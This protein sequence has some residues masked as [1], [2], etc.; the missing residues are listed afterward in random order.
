MLSYFE[1]LF[2]WSISYWMNCSSFHLGLVFQGID[3]FHLSCQI[4]VCR[5]FCCIPLFF[6]D[7]CRAHNNILCFIQIMII[8]VFSLF[9]F[10]SFA[11]GLSFL[12]I[13]SK[14]Q[15]FV[16]WFFYFFCFDFIYFFSW[17]YYF[18]SS[19]YFVLF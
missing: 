3:L 6:F 8:S 11:R 10:I 16:Y 19:V 1:D 15:I 5:A 13:F 14:S 2:K 4:Y 9:L 12:L 18:L 7:V 17:F